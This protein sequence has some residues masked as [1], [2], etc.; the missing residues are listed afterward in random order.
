MIRADCRF[1]GKSETLA[2]LGLN[3]LQEVRERLGLCYHLRPLKP[4]EI[5][6]YLE[7]RLKWAGLKKTVFPSDIADQIW[8]HAQGN[9]RRI[10]RLA[11]KCLL[12]AASNRR[13][14]IDGPCLEEAASET[15]FQQFRKDEGDLC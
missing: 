5:E 10:N 9:P 6:P 8:R 7:K 13:E 4:Q 1:M 14:L 15:S 2:T 11:E 12:S 3:E